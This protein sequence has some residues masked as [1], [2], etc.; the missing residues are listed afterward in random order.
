MKISFIREKI[1]TIHLSVML[2]PFCD[3]P[4]RCKIR[5]YVAS[6]VKNMED[7]SLQG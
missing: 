1:I 7:V 4:S 5:R 2:I 3:E 6:T